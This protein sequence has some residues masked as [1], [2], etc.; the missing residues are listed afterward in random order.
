MSATVHG[1]GGEPEEPT[2][3]DFPSLGAFGAVLATERTAAR[4]RRRSLAGAVPRGVTLGSV[5]VAVLVV[6]GTA[7]AGLTALTGSPIPAPLRSDDTVTVWPTDGASQLATVR[8]ADPEG[9]PAWGVRIGKADGG[10][11]CAGVGQVQGDALG[12]VGRDGRFRALPEQL[13][14]G[15]VSAPTPGHP[16]VATRAVAGDRRDPY[17]VAL[18]GTTVLYGV[19]GDRLRRVVVRTP[20][21]RARPLK[22]DRDGVFVLALRGLPEQA[23]PVVDLTWAGGQRRRVDLRRLSNVPDPEGGAPWTV[24]GSDQVM[25]TARRGDRRSPSRPARVGPACFS[26]LS[27][28]G[29]FA[30]LCGSRQR[31]AWVIRPAGTPVPRADSSRSTRRWAGPSRTVVAVRAAPGAA[32]VVTAAGRAWPV[33]WAGSF[34]DAHRSVHRDVGWVA[35]LPARIAPDGVRVRDGGRSV[36]TAPATL[37][38]GR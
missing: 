23:Q 24:S 18:D 33:R 28:D 30:R 17:G 8:A 4:A 2:L 25:T 27:R 11:V 5:G 6:T 37:G 10:L 13:G 7:A 14:G 22:A 29:G 12:I 3:D 38:G 34:G 32:P 31:G 21:G 36:P 9:G 19:G 35:V 26:V 20:D 15:C 16:I 1:P